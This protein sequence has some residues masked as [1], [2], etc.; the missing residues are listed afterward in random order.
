MNLSVL[1]RKL[2][3]NK[4]SVIRTFTVVLLTLVLSSTTIPITSYAAMSNPPSV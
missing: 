1:G 3:R 4:P 2:N